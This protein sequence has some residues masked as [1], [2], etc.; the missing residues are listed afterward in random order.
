[1]FKFSQKRRKSL[2]SGFSVTE[3]LIGSILAAVAVSGL[4]LIMVNILQENQQEQAKGS[5]EDD[6]RRALDYIANDLREAVYVYTGEQLEG[7]RQPAPNVIAGLT[8]YLPNFGTG[9]RPI[10]AFWKVENLPY[11]GTDSFPAG[12]VG[13][14]CATLFPNN[15]AQIDRC[16]RTSYL[17]F[18]GLYPIDG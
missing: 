12:N 18:S 9:V 6:M 3:L 1:M 16:G 8:T 2:I 10:L 13:D 17:Y 15:R 14:N 11:N 7:Q 4:L 5:V